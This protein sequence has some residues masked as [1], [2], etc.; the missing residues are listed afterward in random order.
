MGSHLRFR[1][2]LNDGKVNR[3]VELLNIIGQCKDEDNLFWY[4]DKQ[5]R[6][7]V[8]SAY[9]SSQRPGTHIG[10]RPRKDDL[11]SQ[12]TIQCFTLLLAEQAALT[13]HNFMKRGVQICSMCWFCECEVK[14]ISLS[15][16]ILER[17]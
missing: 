15:F 10:G 12:D 17:Q 5:G 7:S 16:Y 3:V 4:L 11:G 9:R 6:Y 13:Q 14:T 2:H 1:R 8:G